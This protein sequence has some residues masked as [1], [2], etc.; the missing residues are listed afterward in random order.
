MYSCSELETISKRYVQQ[1]F[2]EVCG[3]EEF[4]QLS[5]ERLLLL[6][7]CDRLQVSGENEVFEAAL[8]WVSSRP[9]VRAN[10]M[11][12]LLQQVRLPLLDI[13][14]L[15]NVVLRTEYVRTCAKCQNLVANAIRIKGD[16]S[17][18]PGIHTRS[19][20]QGIFVLG[21][22]NSVDCQLKSV[23][24]YDFKEDRW[25]YVVGLQYTKQS[26]Q[27]SILEEPA[28]HPPRKSAEP[29]I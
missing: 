12:R 28:G 1:H 9:E 20:P 13:N 6:L 22:R 14:Y 23:E 15:Q 5:E 3:Y 2:S 29:I 10:C 4:R 25:H 24:R 8:Q 26:F 16:I 7:A 11:C 21:G 17:L 18:A 27:C 19:Q